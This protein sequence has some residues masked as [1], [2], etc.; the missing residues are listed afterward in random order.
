MCCKCCEL[1]S[2]IV[3]LHTRGC[4]EELITTFPEL[5]I[6]RSAGLIPVPKVFLSSPGIPSFATS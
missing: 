6:C 5:L 2:G 1:S 4:L 3:D